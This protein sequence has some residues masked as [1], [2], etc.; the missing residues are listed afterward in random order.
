MP[1]RKPPIQ[2]YYAH[3]SA[4]RPRP[5]SGAAVAQE[6]PSTSA[7]ARQATETSTSPKAQA[8]ALTLTSTA[9]AVSDVPSSLPPSVARGARARAATAASLGRPCHPR[10]P[11]R[12]R[13]LRDASTSSSAAAMYLNLVEGAAATPPSSLL[14]KLAK[15]AKAKGLGSLGLKNDSFG[16]VKTVV[17]MH[18]GKTSAEDIKALGET[19]GVEVKVLSDLLDSTS[20][21][22]YKELPSIGKTDLSTSKYP[23][24]WALN[25][26]CVTFLVLF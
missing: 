16:P 23:V 8:A 5:L 9:V 7:S 11:T 19:N 13:Q 6:A 10:L 12:R 3:Q 1:P 17:L 14:Q 18:K 20:P 25:G 22:N 15:D 26:Y 4:P 24:S 21:A 2:S